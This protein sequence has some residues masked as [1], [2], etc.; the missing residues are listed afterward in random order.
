MILAPRRAHGSCYR[1]GGDPHYTVGP[2]TISQDT[3]RGSAEI[4]EIR[5]ESEFPAR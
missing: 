5:S 1:K 2:Y 4:V 3:D